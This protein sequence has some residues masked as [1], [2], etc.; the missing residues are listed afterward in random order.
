MKLP[1]DK[2]PD[3]IRVRQVLCNR[4]GRLVLLR[5]CRVMLSDCRG[6]IRLLQL[7]NGDIF[8]LSDRNNVLNLY[9]DHGTDRVETIET[10]I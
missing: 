3:S 8:L 1:V 2:G 6:V 10:D 9:H 5:K 7:S 4:T